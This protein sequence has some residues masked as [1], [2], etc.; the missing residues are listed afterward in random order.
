MQ[1][2]KTAVVVVL[3]LVVLY[4]AYIAINGSE[5]EL[6]PELQSMLANESE[7]GVDVSMPGFSSGGLSPSSGLTPGTPFASDS[8]F[9]PGTA[10]SNAPNP[11]FGKPT[12]ATSTAPKTLAPPKLTNIP[13]FPS[14]M[15][16][17]QTLP[18]NVSAE[19][20]KAAIKTEAP[21]FSLNIDAPNSMS[22]PGKVASQTT[23]TDEVIPPLP[24]SGLDT[25]EA[26][27][28]NVASNA[29]IKKANITGRSFENAKSA[30]IEQVDRGEFKERWQR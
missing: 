30:A 24:P 17:P 8:P 27:K 5:T 25:G 20:P 28:T 21:S 13:T 9:N 16:L 14:N 15:D 22:F 2:I 18:S 19:P 4:G 6:P 26:N 7:M 1:T 10:F 3:L 11:A 23:A 12:S 29:T